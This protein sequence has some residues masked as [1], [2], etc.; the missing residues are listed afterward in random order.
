MNVQKEHSCRLASCS[1]GPPQI[2]AQ[3]LSRGGRVDSFQ[4]YDWP[5]VTFPVISLVADVSSPTTHVMHLSMF[6]D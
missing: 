4:A 2:R 3:L 5:A 6:S 1:A